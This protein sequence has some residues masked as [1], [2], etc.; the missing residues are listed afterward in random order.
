M[1]HDDDAPAAVPL[2][3]AVFAAHEPDV[4][5]RPA[6]AEVEIVPPVQEVVLTA[7]EDAVEASWHA[8]PDVIAVDV[9]RDGSV[10]VPAGTTSFRDTGADADRT[11][12]LVA[13]YRRP[14]GATT[15]AEPVRADHRNRAAAS[16]PPVTGVRAR[17]FGVELLVSWTW[18]ELSLIHI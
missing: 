4:W 12:L 17:R 11:Y 2:G 14:D 9:H 5:S 18:P 16:L 3:Y 6:R 7:T 10:P 15:A 1:V 8:H 13:R